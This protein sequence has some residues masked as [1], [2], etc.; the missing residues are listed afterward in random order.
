MSQWIAYSKLKPD[1]Y[2]VYTKALNPWWPKSS[3]PACQISFM[4][5]WD[6]YSSTTMPEW[7]C[8]SVFNHQSMASLTSPQCAPMIKYWPSIIYWLLIEWRPMRAQAGLS[9]TQPHLTLWWQQSKGKLMLMSSDDDI[10][11]TTTALTWNWNWLRWHEPNDTEWQQIK[12]NK[13]EQTQTATQRL[14]QEESGQNLIKLTPPPLTFLI[15][16]SCSWNYMW[17]GPHTHPH[18]IKSHHL[19]VSSP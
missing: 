9:N 6:V 2:T 16:N 4:Y 10:T 7:R 14:K 1:T 18:K 5:T 17:G 11:M 19:I 8:G 3:C 13:T 12:P 15:Q